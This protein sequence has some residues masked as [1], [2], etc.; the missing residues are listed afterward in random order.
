MAVESAPATKS[1]KLDPITFEILRHRLWAINEEAA[2]TMKLVSGST[3]ATEANDLNTSIMDARGD[4]VAVA[5]YSL[6]KATTMQCVVQD[7]LREYEENPG[8]APG[9]GFLCNDAYVGVQHQNDV[10][11]VMPFFHEGELL[12]WVGAEVHQV[13]V[14]GPVPGNVQVGAQSI[15]GEAPLIPPIKIIEGGTLRRDLERNYLLRSRTPE[16]LALD[17]RAK[18]A[19]CNVAA[20]RLGQLADQYGNETTQQLMDDVLTT[21]EARF[22]ARLAALPDGIWRHVTYL[23]FDGDVYPIRVAMTKEGDALTF[24]F[25]GTAKQAPAIINCTEPSLVAVLLGYVCISLCWDIPWS[26]SAVGRAVTVVPEPGSVVACDWPGGVSKSTTSVCWA[27][28]KTVGLLIGRM[29]ACSDRWRHKAMASWQGAM[30]AEE[31]HGRDWRGRDFGTTVIDSMAGAGG[32]R[33]FRDGIDTGGYLGSMGM[34]IPNV[35]TYEFEYPILYLYRRQQCDGGGAGTFR[36]G[37]SISKAYVVNGV[38]EIPTFVMHCVGV[39]MPLSPGSCGGFPAGTNQLSIK[40]GSNA[41][42]LLESGTIPTSPEEVSGELEV[43]HGIARTSLHKRDA[44]F[45]SPMGAGG[46]GDPLDRDPELVRRDVEAEIVSSGSAERI[47]GVVVEDGKVDVG[48]T[49]RAREEIRRDRL[50]AASEG[51]PGPAVASGAEPLLRVGDRLLLVEGEDGH[52]LACSCGRG[53]APVEENFKGWV[54]ERRRPLRDI[55]P[56]ADPFGIGRDRFEFREYY[57]PACGSL[58]ATDV[59]ETEEPVVWELDLAP[60]VGAAR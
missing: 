34:A 46:F 25:R 53:L 4:V 14:G 26:P 27:V 49:A 3:V 8:I 22:R 44:Y 17:L 21:T 36:G 20:Q 12:G 40:R 31:V 6:A 29:L 37:T 1:P 54:P 33:T 50:A 23:D 45:C 28:G 18:W 10:A 39:A 52:V 47:Y 19:A 59:V 57:C 2:T 11:L 48:A 55:G 9:D 15:F 51:R 42:D 32:A 35:E 38:E 41:R 24:D 60:A 7:I 43:F 13:D 56:Q 5:R 16:L 30:I 58:L